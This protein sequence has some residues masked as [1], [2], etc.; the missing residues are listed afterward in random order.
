[1]HQLSQECFAARDLAER[2]N[3]ST[4]PEAR[5]ALIGLAQVAWLAADISPSVPEWLQT[6]P[7]SAAL[8]DLPTTG[9]EETFMLAAAMVEAQEDFLR[10]L[11]GRCAAQPDVS[12]SD[13]LRKE[14]QHSLVERSRDPATDLCVRI[15][16]V[17][18]LDLLGDP[19]FEPRQGHLGR[20]LRPPMVAMA[21]GAYAIGSDEG[22]EK[23]EARRHEVQLA[24]FA[25]GRF[26]VTNAEFK[27][28]V[29]AGGYQ[30][31][32]WW[33]TPTAQR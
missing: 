28:F 6:L 33:D 21:G 11:A 18:A 20:F 22:L 2:F 12:V 8:P 17:P 1:M 15:S 30:D 7:E 27:C 25:L 19:R 3:A 13:H 26:P 9:W 24:P 23:D 32:R 16:A 4:A 29:G 10:A 31:S 14:L 5:A